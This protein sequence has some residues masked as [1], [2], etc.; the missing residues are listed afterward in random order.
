[1]KKATQV[2]ESAQM[3]VLD[4]FELGMRV[5]LWHCRLSSIRFYYSV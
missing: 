5:S 4:T 2:K 1:M 3:K